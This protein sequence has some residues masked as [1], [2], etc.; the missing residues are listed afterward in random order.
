MSTYDLNTSD[1]VRDD[2][3][4]L[5]ALDEI[6]PMETGS[7]GFELETE[8]QVADSIE[9]LNQMPEIQPEQWESLDTTERL[10]ALQTVENHLAEIQNRPP[11]AVEAAEMGPNEF[12]GYDGQSIKI[13]QE[14]LS[15][16]QPV[17]ENVDTIVHEGRHAY[18]DFVV[19]HPETI[20]DPSIAQ[21]WEEN[22]DNYLD[23]Q[24]YGA[25]LY[26]SQPVEADAWSYAASVRN[27]VYGK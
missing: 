15:G 22:F 26:N 16:G 21:A 3:E 20:S 4:D 19:A 12:G 13:N 6:T 27:G 11:V 18:Q 9:T 5:E 17:D 24:T 2:S 25:E 8:G 23:L 10:G 7:R 14:H 1:D